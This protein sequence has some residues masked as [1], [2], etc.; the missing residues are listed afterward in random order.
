MIFDPAEY[1]RYKGTPEDITYREATEEET[2]RLRRL[3]DV[4]SKLSGPISVIFI[5]FSCA[6]FVYFATHDEF[7]QIFMYG[8]GLFVILSVVNTLKQYKITRKSIAYEIAE[9]IMVGY[10]EINNRP[11]MS[12]WCEKDQVYIPSLR[13]LSTFHRSQNMPLLIVRGDQGDGKKPVY[14]VVTAA[15]DP[16]I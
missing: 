11:Y 5:V 12:V 3:E 8:A 1:T 7:S 13:Y 16:I 9:G 10:K 6:L 15:N 2:E 14:F 4:R